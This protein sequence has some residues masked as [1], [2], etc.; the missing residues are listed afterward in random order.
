VEKTRPVNG[1]ERSKLTL[2][3]LEA[4]AMTDKAPLVSP[5]TVEERSMGGAAQLWK[6]FK[7]EALKIADDVYYDRLTCSLEEAFA[8][9]SMPKLPETL[10]ATEE[11]PLMGASLDTDVRNVA[12]EDAA[13]M[14]EHADIRRLGEG[15]VRMRI[16]ADIRAMK[17][18][19]AAR[20]EP[21]PGDALVI[22]KL[23]Q[24]SLGTETQTEL[25]QRKILG[26]VINRLERV[27]PGDRAM[28]GARP[29]NTEICADCNHAALLHGWPEGRCYAQPHQTGDGKRCH[30]E[31]F[32]AAAIERSQTPQGANSQDGQ[33]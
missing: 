15:E 21:G 20:R 17:S 2:R 13:Q 14:A 9:M 22:V 11:T 10:A 6:L 23:L 28:A 29:E 7:V 3:P 33:Q 18:P 19:L 26:V 27:G 30:C 4:I 32:R 1:V 31:Q 8:L 25:D 5:E 12:L 16:A 24:E